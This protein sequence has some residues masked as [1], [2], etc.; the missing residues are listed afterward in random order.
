M[1]VTRTLTSYRSRMFPLVR[2]ENPEGSD[3]SLA[4]F[5]LHV[6]VLQPEDYNTL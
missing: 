1:Q 4:T 5:E 6:L 2:I 3:D